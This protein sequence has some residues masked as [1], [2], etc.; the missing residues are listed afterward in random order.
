MRVTYPIFAVNK[1]SLSLELFR[2]TPP[3][4][5]G[6]DTKYVLTRQPTLV[7]LISG[8]IALMRSCAFI[9]LKTCLHFNYNREV[10]PGCDIAC[11][12]LRREALGVSS[13]QSV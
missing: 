5:G 12:V 1:W 3:H 4:A 9:V 6:G 2:A 13:Q 8:S 10:G 11:T 7:A